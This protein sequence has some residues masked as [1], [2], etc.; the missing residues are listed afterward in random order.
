MRLRDRVRRFFQ[1]P[2]VDETDHTIPSSQQV[3]FQEW[4]GRKEAAIHDSLGFGYAYGGFEPYT[5]RTNV[6]RNLPDRIQRDSIEQAHAIYK[7]NPLASRAV[8]I[9]AEYVIG[10]GIQFTALDKEVSRVLSRHWDD[11]TNRWS[12]LQL[13]R[14]RE[15]GLTGELIVPAFVNSQNG[16]VTLGHIDP[17]VVDSVLVDP[18]NNLRVYAVI[19]KRTGSGTSRDRHLKAYRVIS[20][21]DYIPPDNPAY[22]KRLGLPENRAMANTWGV[23]YWKGKKETLKNAHTLSDSSIGSVKIE[24]AGQ[25][26]YQKVNAPIGSTRGWSDLLPSMDWIDAHDQFLFANVEKAINSARYI[27]DIVL[28][29][30]TEEQQEEWFEKNKTLFTAGDWFVHNENV[31]AKHQSPDLRMEDTS[32]FGDMLKN[33]ALSGVGHPPLW[34]AESGQSRAAAPE[35]TEPSFKHIRTRQREFAY[36]VSEIFRFC[37]DQAEIR[38][39]LK[40]DGRVRDTSSKGV[41]TRTFYLR[42]PD[43]SSKDLRMLSIAI[44]N[45]AK[46]LKEMVEMGKEV[47]TPDFGGGAGGMGGGPPGMNP[48]GGG[49]KAKAKPKSS[50]GGDSGGGKVGEADVETDKEKKPED[51]EMDKDGEEDGDGKDGDGKEDKETKYRGMTPEEASRIFN[52]SLEMLGFDAWKDEPFSRDV[53]GDPEFST[54]K[55]FKRLSESVKREEHRDEINS[56]GSTF[57]L[58]PDHADY[59]KDQWSEMQEALLTRAIQSE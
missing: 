7:F 3:E 35:M 34:Y 26:F 49:A 41:E 22:G 38:G 39:Y 9:T 25:C 4:K 18:L 58:Y 51:K 32:T 19:L 42:M 36:L 16:A 13:A 23:K 45:I 5:A 28:H 55:V 54:T 15:L 56:R 8:N 37:I 2:P 10:D 29:G 17:Q 1:E 44:A 46:A 57:Y 27:L 59:T 24:W 50:S 53:A 33:Q 11:P 52:R 31:E 40:V 48:A 6:R 43:V 20:V 21:A 14:V 12:S 30:M 47:P